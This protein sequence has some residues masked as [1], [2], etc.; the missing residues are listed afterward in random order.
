MD[1]NI[2]SVLHKVVQLTRQN[3]EFNTELRKALDIAP[4]ADCIS[5]NDERINQIYEY[6]IEHIIRR[7]ATEFYA[8]FPIEPIKSQLID[9]FVNME[10]FRRKD[11]FGNFCI[12]L[13]QQIENITNKL[14]EDRGLSIIVEKMWSYPAYVKEGKISDRPESDYCIAKLIFPGEN[15][16][17]HQPYYFEKSKKTLQNQYANDKIRIIVYFLGYKAA[18]RSTDYDTFVEITSLMN[19]IYQCRNM[20]H[21]GNTLNEWEE[22]TINRILPMK[23]FCYFLY[24]GALAQYI[25]YVK[26]GLKELNTIQQY[27]ESLEDKKVKLGGPKTLGFIE[28]SE[29]DKNKKT[30]K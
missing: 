18:M 15:K 6:C 1:D 16:N 11:D 20:N 19:D 12:A 23:S 29:E 22:K 9:D 2:K 3:S 5:I 13:Y 8:D 7:Q 28:L 24:L 27:A 17:S 14:C 25:H 10:F 26:E 30:F 21:R 4:S